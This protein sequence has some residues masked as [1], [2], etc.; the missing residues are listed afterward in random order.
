MTRSYYD[1]EAAHYDA[2]RNGVEQ[3]DKTPPTSEAAQAAR[4]RAIL[5]KRLRVVDPDDPRRTS[6]T[7]CNG[8]KALKPELF[9]ASDYSFPMPQ[10]PN[11]PT[12]GLNLHPNFRPTC[13]AQNELGYDVRLY[14]LSVDVDQASGQCKK[15]GSDC[16]TGVQCGYVGDV[17]FILSIVAPDGSGSPPLPNLYMKHPITGVLMSAL[18][19]VSFSQSGNES[20]A[21]YVVS[22]TTNLDCG[23]GANVNL[24][25][26]TIDPYPASGAWS[27]KTY[28]NGGGYI[29]LGCGSCSK[30]GK[31]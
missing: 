3:S 5:D 9:I 29:E 31:F 14:I 26:A 7:V 20:T 17:W 25:M 24:D 12:Y 15:S 1:F 2:L 11:S 19:P 16:I 23:A 6:D 27:S 8:C 30:G 22:W 10:R 4:S 13:N 28:Q 18:V 21:S